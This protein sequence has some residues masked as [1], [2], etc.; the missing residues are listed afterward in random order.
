MPQI[1][2][3]EGPQVRTQALQPVLQRAPDVSSGPQTIARGLGAVAETFDRRIDRDTTDEAFRLEAQYRNDWAQER[4]RLRNQYKGDQADQ[5]LTA[6]SDWWKKAPSLYSD[7]A[8][9][10][11]KQKANRAL[12]S[13]ALQAQD[14]ALGY[15]EG[16]KK[17]AREI[18]YRTLQN[19]RI[20]EAGQIIT[21]A[22]AR[23][24]SATTAAEIRRSAIEYA[25][26]EGLSSDVG[27]AM[28]R[29]QMARFHADVALSLASKPGGAAAAQAYLTEFGKDI[30]L[31]VRTRVD[32]VVKGE[33]DNQFATQFAASV[34]TK[35][36]AEQLADAAKI[37]DSDRREKALTQVRNNQALIKAAQQEREQAASDQAW[38]LVARGQSV[39]EVTLAQMNGTERVRLQDYVVEKAKKALEGTPVKTDWPTYINLRERIAA[40]EKINLTQYSLKLAGGEIEKLLDLQTQVAKPGKQDSMLTDSQRIDQALV[41]LGID[42]TSKNGAPQAGQFAAEVDRR[43]RAASAEKGGKELTADEKQAIVDRVAMDKVYVDEFGTDPQ[44]P[45][46][47]LTP[48]ELANAYVV[49]NGKNVKLSSVPVRDRQ[50]IVAALRATGQAP[51]EQAIVEMYLKG[52]QGGA[53]STPAAPGAARAPTPGTA[54][55]PAPAAPR[56]PA[57]PQAV[58]DA[59]ADIGAPAGAH[60]ARAP[61]PATAAP[62]PVSAAPAANE[63][64]RTREVAPA[65]TDQEKRL[66]ELVTSLRSKNVDLAGFTDEKILEAFRANSPEQRRARLQTLEDANKRYAAAPTPARTPAPV[67]APAPAARAPAAPP[68]SN[69]RSQAGPT[70]QEMAENRRAEQVREAREEVSTLESLVRSNEADIKQATQ[71]RNAAEVSRLEELRQQN[72]ADLDAARARLQ[73]LQRAAR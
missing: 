32:G 54:P 64:I 52:Q 19:Q 72:Q 70:A 68:A 24:V 8:S 50:Q 51:T 3:Y 25:A 9:P 5:Y 2:L 49:V 7:Q 12:V 22:N 10:M 23:A 62:A 56:A 69:G 59:F 39:P 71:K 73:A 35:P 42:K 41:G 13:M 34:A 4:A 15:V 20:T 55:A 40:G 48:D 28:A 67:P 53:R 21:P 27:E 30:P 17:R 14:E 45:L 6:A 1:P 36:L 44:K 38:Q 26:G 33:A 65:S 18:N 60:A 46:A 43:V 63:P 58:A 66:M 29:D 16:E 11:A 61:A 57:S 37:E 31:E 47:L